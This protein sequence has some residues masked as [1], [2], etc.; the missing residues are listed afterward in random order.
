M[1]KVHNIWITVYSKP[2]DDEDKVL[3]GLLYLIPFDLQAEKIQ[4]SKKVAT[5]TEERKIKI[6]QVHLKKT[7]HINSFLKNLAS[8]L[9]LE[10]ITL[11]KKQKESR[12]DVENHFFI[13]FDKQKLIRKELHITD[14]GSCYHIKMSIAAFPT[15]REN[16]LKV[17]DSLF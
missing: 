1:K 7:R 8:E 16:A 11:L 17:I 15:T 4:L 2:E 5:S 14:R 3:S 9:T 13:R 6:F 10:Q 12:L